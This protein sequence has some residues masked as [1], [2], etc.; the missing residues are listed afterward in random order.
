MISSEIHEQ[1]KQLHQELGNLISEVQKSG[2][3]A[4]F[5][6]AIQQNAISIYNKASGLN[7]KNENSHPAQE[8]LAEDKKAFVPFSQPAVVNPP[9]IKKE[10]VTPPLPLINIP[11]SNANTTPVEEKKSAPAVKTIVSD[12]RN[13]EEEISINERFSKGKVPVLNYAEKSKET[14]I[15]DLSKAI[16]I[17]KKF[18]FINLLFAGNSDAY[19]N[20]INN[21]QNSDSYE[22]AV[23]YLETEISNTPDWEENEKLGSEFFALVRRRFMK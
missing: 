7:K 18:E 11:E 2:D 16:S 8:T 20:C 12:S 13:D 17:G 1:I 21:I 5:I 10:I 3:K 22:T 6:S 15:K 23:T 19:K 9:E 4:F 14:P